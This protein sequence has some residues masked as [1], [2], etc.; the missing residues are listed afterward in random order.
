MCKK[1]NKNKFRY[2]YSDETPI[3]GKIEKIAKE[4]YVAAPPKITPEL[5]EGVWIESK[6]NVPITK[7]FLLMNRIII[8]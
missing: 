3:L 7:I 1:S 2:L 8:F 4:I 6:A 5:K